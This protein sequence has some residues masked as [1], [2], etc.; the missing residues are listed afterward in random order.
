[1]VFNMIRTLDWIVALHVKALILATAHNLLH[2]RF[3]GHFQSI[4][5]IYKGE[6]IEDSNYYVRKAL[7]FK[8]ILHLRRSLTS[9]CMEVDHY[10]V[11][12]QKVPSYRKMYI[13]QIEPF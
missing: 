12:F 3:V 7:E 9:K 1:M 5:A 10:I 13:I 11:S 8:I 2:V 6:H 4:N